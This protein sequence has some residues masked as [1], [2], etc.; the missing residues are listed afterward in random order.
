MLGFP[1]DEISIKMFWIASQLDERFVALLPVS[2]DPESYTNL[3]GNMLVIDDTVK[4]MAKCFDAISKG[5]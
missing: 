1:E 4:R 3:A 5:E 2:F